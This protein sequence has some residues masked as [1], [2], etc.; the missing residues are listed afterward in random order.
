MAFART[1]VETRDASSIIDEQIELYPRLRDL[2]D[3]L[4][5][6]LSREPELG[7]PVPATQPQLL[8]V[9][10]R[11]W[12]RPGLPVILIA[13][14]YSDEQVFVQAIRVSASAADD[15]GF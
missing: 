4:L 3:G 10:S 13:Y 1:I 15:V 9:H 12:Q 2:Y 7:Y 5:W 11:D 14:T 6:R 8:L